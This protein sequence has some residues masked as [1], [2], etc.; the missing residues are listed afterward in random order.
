MNTHISYTEAMDFPEA[1]GEIVR[2]VRKGKGKLK[3]T[4]PSTWTWSFLSWVT[5]QSFTLGQ[6]LRGEDIVT[7]GPIVEARLFAE[8]GRAS[9]AGDINC[10]P[11][12]VMD[13]AYPNLRRKP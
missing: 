2:K 1:V 3:D 11:L 13:H 12:W 7:H 9:A 6:I 10:V 5:T 8:C 4:D